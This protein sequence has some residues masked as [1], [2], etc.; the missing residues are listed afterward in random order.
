MISAGEESGDL[1]GAALLDK[2]KEIAPHLTFS[3]LGGDRMAKSGAELLAH[4]K[5]TAVMGVAEI[6]GSFGKILAIRKSLVEH[7]ERERPDA[8]VLV[9]FPDFNFHLA[10]KAT[11][12]NIPVIYY[13][14]PQVWAW[15]EGRLKFLRKNTRRR[16]LIF[17]FELKF[18]EERGLDA[19]LVGHPLL[20]EMEFKPKPASR[21]ALGLPPGGRTL[22]LLP[23]SRAKLFAK[24]APAVF[25]A[26]E[27]LRADFPD[28]TVAAALAPSLPRRLADETLEAF[29]RDFAKSVILYEGRSQELLNASDA[30]LLASGTSAL[31]GAILGV[32][33]VVAYKMNFLSYLLAKLLVKIPR[34]S[35]PN[36]VLGSAAVPELI[37]GKATAE[38]LADAL[39]PFLADPAA[40]ERTAKNLASVREALGGPGA[41]EKVVN[42]ILEETGDREKTG[43]ARG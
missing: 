42:I 12:L 31:E 1:H 21:A 38:N 2:A 37:Q 33:M 4:M 39:K 34:V 41:S 8:L 15:R 32:P 3:G 18:Y 24:L 17:P 23:G 6:F 29:P 30:A 9:D 43:G 27:I 40:R 13:I 19:D 36:I 14:C 25:G 35:L 28:L 20:D 16:A 26:A 11:A 5:N 10:K 22:A 7:M